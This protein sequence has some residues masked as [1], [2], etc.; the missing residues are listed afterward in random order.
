MSRR[1]D[2]DSEPMGWIRGHTYIGPVRQFRVI[3]CFDSYGPEIQV[4]S[5]P[6]NGSYSW[7]VISR[8][9]NR[10]VDKSWQ[11]QE[12]TSQDVEIS[13]S[14]TVGQSHAITSSIEQTDASKQQ[15]QSI[16]MKC[17]SEEFIQIDRRKWNEIPARDS[18]ERF[19]LL[20]TAL[21]R[22]RELE[23]REFDGAVQWRSL[24]PKPRRDF[25]CE[26]A[27]TFSDCQW[28]GYLY[29]GSN[30]PRFQYCVDSNNNVLYCS[31]HPRSPTRR[32]D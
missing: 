15:E 13:S 26:G 5:M 2:Q 30:K 31:C 16:P 9:S 7:N 18:V 25:D 23:H 11:D 22:H 3:C 1:D 32:C 21:G 20:M 29:R 24:F 12:D 27:R 14:T 17:P 19:L 4:P 10:F 8:G 6:K 28:M